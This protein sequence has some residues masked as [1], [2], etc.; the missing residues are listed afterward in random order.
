MES[1]RRESTFSLLL[2]SSDA[3]PLADK[4]Q[5][6]PYDNRRYLETLRKDFDEDAKCLFRASE[7]GGDDIYSVRI[8][9]QRDDYEDEDGLCTIEFGYLQVKR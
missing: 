2:N 1:A 8:G 3:V 4:L 7:A 5:G 9:G 6:T